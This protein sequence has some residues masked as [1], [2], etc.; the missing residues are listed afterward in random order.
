MN[1]NST[2]ERH[3]PSFARHVGVDHSGAETPRSSLPGLRVYVA[4]G[5]GL[6]IEDLPPPSPR[7]H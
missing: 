4:E 3:I 5:D 6:P 1:A 7:K 2:A